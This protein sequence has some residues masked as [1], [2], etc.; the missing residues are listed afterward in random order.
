[1]IEGASFVGRGL[2]FNSAGRVRR[3]R[4]FPSPSATSRSE[5]LRK[6]RLRDEGGPLRRVIAILSRRSFLLTGGAIGALLPKS[7]LSETLFVEQDFTIEVTAGPSPSS[8]GDVTGAGPAR[9][10]TSGEEVVSGLSGPVSVSLNQT[11]SGRQF[12][13]NGG[14]WRSSPL[15]NVRNGDRVQVRLTSAETGQTQTDLSLRIGERDVP[16][17]VTTKTL[18]NPRFV[19]TGN[20]AMP[21]HNAGDLVFA[22]AFR[23][24]ST[25]PISVPQGW[26][27][28]SRKT[29]SSTALAP[30]TNCN[31]V[32]VYRY[33]PV[34][35]STTAPFGGA[36]RVLY[37]VYRDA[38]VSPQVAARSYFMA[39]VLSRLQY[40]ANDAFANNAWNVV[41]T[42][43]A[44]NDHTRDGSIDA[45]ANHTLRLA[46]TGTDS[47]HL[48]TYD[49]NGIRA[50]F[51]R[52]HTSRVG[53]NT[54][55]GG[56]VTFVARVG[57]G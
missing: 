57:P 38:T 35:N 13:V 19:R 45:L 4:L 44:R 3:A 17:S 27:I 33:A 53:R 7:S 12:R 30:W 5:N 28:L 25:S 29:W 1:M 52:D 41:F 24:G 10:V 11:G 42:G 43:W 50:G 23:R 51:A 47:V 15:S 54:N 40:D 22:L 26:T 37:S 36:T 16:F 9:V 55:G 32:L 56:F 18:S 48:D 2:T 31:G 8:F 46:S 6:N 20:N 21:S 39:S 49:S 34:R 14:G